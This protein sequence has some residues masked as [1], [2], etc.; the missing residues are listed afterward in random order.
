MVVMLHRTTL[1]SVN[2]KP[3]CAYW[4]VMTSPSLKAR[5]G[6]VL[7]F[8]PSKSTTADRET[9]VACAVDIRPVVIRATPRDLRVNVMFFY[10]LIRGCTTPLIRK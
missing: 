2:S 10:R 9:R 5:G 7:P 4:L 3:K 6:R 8:T 1:V